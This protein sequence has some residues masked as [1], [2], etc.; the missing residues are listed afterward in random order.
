MLISLCVVLEH[1]PQGHSFLGRKKE[2]CFR[3]GSI[4]DMGRNTKGI[5]RRKP[6]FDDAGKG[7]SFAA[8]TK[9]PMAI[10][11]CQGTKDL[12]RLRSRETG[13]NHSDE[14][15]ARQAKPDERSVFI[16]GSP[17]GLRSIGLAPVAKVTNPTMMRIRRAISMPA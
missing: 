9:P 17:C 6:K 1:R 16:D 14:M 10:T 5:Y 3:F 15:M 12:R 7:N 4:A 8:R 13:R 11:K 2:A